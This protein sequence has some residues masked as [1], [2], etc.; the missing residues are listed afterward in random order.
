MSNLKSLFNKN[1][2]VKIN[3][4]EIL[5]LDLLD[6]LKK[7]A[8]RML[9]DYNDGIVDPYKNNSREDPRFYIENKIGNLLYYGCP[10]EHRFRIGKGSANIRD[11]KNYLYGKRVLLAE[12]N[13]S[14]ELIN[15]IE[16]NKVLS[17]VSDFFETDTEN[18]SFHNG[19]LSRVFP[20]CTGESGKFHID[21][22]GFVK[23]RSILLDPN[24]YLINV[25]CF[26][27][28]TSDELAPMRIIPGSHR[29]YIEINNV[30]AK[31][32]KGDPKKNN[33]HQA[34]HIYDELLE[35]L[36]LQKQVKLTGKAGTVVIM[37]SMLLH[38]AT[39]NYTKDSYRDVVILNY[40]KRTDSFFR[41]RY[42]K[43]YSADSKKLINKSKN[44]NLF[45]RSF[46][47]NLRNNINQF[48]TKEFLYKNYNRIN[49]IKI[50]LKNLIRPYYEIYKRKVLHKKFEN[51]RH[52]NVG[53][54]NGW[55][56]KNF[57]C[58]DLAPDVEINFNLNKEKK[59]PFSDNYLQGIYTSHCLEHLKYSEVIYWLK[60]FYRT[61]KNNSILR[62]ITPDMM[63]YLEAYEKKDCYFF[64]WIRDSG[65]YTYDC[66]LRSIVRQFAS[67]VVDNYSDKELYELYK[68]KNKINFLNFFEKQVELIKD[69]NYLWPEIHKSWWSN[70][71]F[72]N[73]LKKIG[74]SSIKVVSQNISDDNIFIGKYLN[75]TRPHMSLFIEAKK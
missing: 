14:Q 29:K 11:D 43:D 71:K 28:D 35:N 47:N 69:E 33:V 51:K 38:S 49:K 75:K 42:F 65:S 52:L 68:M 32:F 63:L 62:I 20:G 3:P 67:P 8:N 5:S 12:R 73:E 60:E 50:S 53:A 56:E 66:W 19:S 72:E 41:K 24:K 16:N 22:P 21:T 55:R 10:L 57:I 27:S 48:S 39:E 1:G 59:L 18:L 45:E 61:L 25:F 31:S 46:K 70:D 7:E 34:G 74:F 44:K 26:L 4:D 13:F 64:N 36:G 15:F 54:G 2:Y 6:R 9:P 37:N 23:N 40:S 17:I 30:L 58:L